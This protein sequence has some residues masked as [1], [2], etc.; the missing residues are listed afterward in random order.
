MLFE[1]VKKREKNKHA[2]KSI[3]HLLVNIYTFWEERG[4]YNKM[5]I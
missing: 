3:T 4:I 2:H 1:N 5:I